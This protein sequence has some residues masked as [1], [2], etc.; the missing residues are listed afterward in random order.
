MHPVCL[1]L[2][3]LQAVA[4]TSAPHLNEQGL[5]SAVKFSF[6][7]S[8]DLVP[9]TECTQGAAL[10]TY[11]FAMRVPAGLGACANLQT[12]CGGATCLTALADSIYGNCPAFTSSGRAA[13]H[14]HA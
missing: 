9:N 14:E 12:L 5:P 7:P 3:A 6:K 13:S 2:L 10:K 4:A 1:T 11:T 8:E